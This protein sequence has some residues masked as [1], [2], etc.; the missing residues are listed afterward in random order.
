MNKI[1]ILAALLVTTTVATAEPMRLTRARADLYTATDGS[2][3][4]TAGCTQTANAMTAQVVSD[5]GRRFVVFYDANGEEEGDC[6]V[7]AVRKASVTRV[8]SR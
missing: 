6:M 8:A 1:I 4:K 3:V 7:R 2:R 5:R